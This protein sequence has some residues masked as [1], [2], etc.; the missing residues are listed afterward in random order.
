MPQVLRHT[1]SKNPT[2]RR[3]RRTRTRIPDTRTAPLRESRSKN[4]YTYLIEVGK[5]DSNT[6][7]VLLLIF[8]SLSHSFLISSS[9]WAC[10]LIGLFVNTKNETYL[11]AA[12]KRPHYYLKIAKISSLLVSKVW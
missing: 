5:Y 10:S 12:Q 7:L 6:G 1:I 4:I 2:T 3:T 9:S 11:K 8:N